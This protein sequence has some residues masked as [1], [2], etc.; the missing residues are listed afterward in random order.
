MVLY[1]NAHI[2]IVLNSMIE[3]FPSYEYYLLRKSH[4][5]IERGRHKR[6]KVTI[7]YNLDD[8]YQDTKY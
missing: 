3:M 6:R 1:K 5:G 2:Q 7:I 4:G 8:V